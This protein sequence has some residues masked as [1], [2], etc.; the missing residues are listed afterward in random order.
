M[1]KK[2]CANGSDNFLCDCGIDAI[3]MVD[4]L[5]RLKTQTSTI[6][7]MKIESNEDL[8]KFD[9]LKAKIRKDVTNLA[10]TIYTTEIHCKLDL[11]DV[12][13]VNSNMNQWVNKENW[14]ALALLIDNAMDLFDESL[15]GQCHEKKV[16]SKK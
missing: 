14:V 7:Q 5:R 3:D 6:A 4:T 8:L 10:E 2:K 12:K 9:E 16:R 11:D 1:S 13:S 15:Y